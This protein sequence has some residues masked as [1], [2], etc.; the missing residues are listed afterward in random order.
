MVGKRDEVH[1]RAA[2]LMAALIGTMTRARVATSQDAVKK[3]LAA[4]R[5]AADMLL[6]GGP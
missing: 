5:R 3:T 6:V 2:T 4:G 1:T